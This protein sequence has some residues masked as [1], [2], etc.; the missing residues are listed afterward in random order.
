MKKTKKMMAVLTA[1]TMALTM[2]APIE[3]PVRG[4]SK[5]AGINVVKVAEEKYENTKLVEGKCGDNVKYIYDENT[6]TLT[7]SGKGEMWMI[8]DSLTD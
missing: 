2:M 8:Q 6:K 1:T 3:M 4:L 7:I 5:I